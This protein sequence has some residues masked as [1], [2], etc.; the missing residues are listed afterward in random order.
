MTVGKGIRAMIGSHVAVG[1]VKTESLS[2][3]DSEG[4]PLSI[5]NDRFVFGLLVGADENFLFLATG[6]DGKPTKA[7]SIV[8]IE[9]LTS[10]ADEIATLLQQI[11]GSEEESS[12]HDGVLN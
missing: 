3:A 4:V 1:L 12:S 2:V 6:D 5:N 9:M 10:D 7:I 11:S 8:N